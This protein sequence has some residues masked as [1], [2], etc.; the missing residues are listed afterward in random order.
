MPKNGSS[1]IERA[2]VTSNHLPVEESE[3]ASGFSRGMP[4]NPCEG[5]IGVSATRDRPAEGVVLNATDL[6]DA[7]I[8]FEYKV[9]GGSYQSSNTIGN[10][11]EGTYTFY[12]R[13]DGKGCEETVQKEVIHCDISLTT[14]STDEEYDLSDG[15]ISATAT[16]SSDSVEWSFDG[17]PWQIGDKSQSWA[18]LD[19]GTYTVKVRDEWGCVESQEVTVGN[20]A[21]TSPPTT[22]TSLTA[23]EN[24]AS[25]SLD[26]SGSTDDEVSVSHYKVYRSTSSGFTADSSTLVKDNLSATSWEDTGASGD[27]YYKVTAVDARGN[28]SSPSNEVSITITDSPP[29]WEN[30]EEVVWLVDNTEPSWDKKG[31]IKANRQA[32]WTITDN[33]T[34]SGGTNKKPTWDTKPDLFE[35]NS[36]ATWDSKLDLLVD[37]QPDWETRAELIV[38]NTKAEWTVTE[39]YTYTA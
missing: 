35:E 4:K 24:V 38:S 3:E 20:I 33:Y 30:R 27:I 7:G 21:D 6:L 18:G 19:D 23:T 36:R 28:E 14:S 8:S 13:G 26:W 11:A 16:T 17:G 5:R 2:S 29:S 1:Y 25:A 34:Y 37:S 22:P 9:E 15:A 12:V 32:Q 10:L 39:N 31:D